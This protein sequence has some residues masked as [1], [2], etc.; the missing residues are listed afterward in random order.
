M[1]IQDV[2]TLVLQHQH[3]EKYEIYKYNY[4]QL[5]FEAY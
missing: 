2:P 3:Q 1:Y 5:E 4:T